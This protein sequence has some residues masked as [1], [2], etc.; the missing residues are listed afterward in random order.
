MAFK[1]NRKPRF[2]REVKFT[3]LDGLEENF[4]VTFEVQPASAMNEA[5]LTDEGQVR[6][7]KT[8]IVGLEG[9]VDD[10]GNAL[11]F[12]PELV[13]LVA[14]RLD[15]RSPIFT[16]YTEAIADLAPKN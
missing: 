13:A 14:D 1:V 8:A 6:F 4:S 2:T 12:G 15:V 5:L 11:P 10:A 16:A 9:I 7:L 3:A